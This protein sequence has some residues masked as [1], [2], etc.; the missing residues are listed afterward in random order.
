MMSDL[1]DNMNHPEEEDDKVILRC[2]ASSIFVAQLLNLKYLSFQW[3]SQ[4]TALIQ[5]ISI[6]YF[7][8]LPVEKQMN[9]KT[10]WQQLANV[11]NGQS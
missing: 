6:L 4:R 10:N 9:I 8:Q 5:S 2:N 1:I 3:S 7:V 11:E